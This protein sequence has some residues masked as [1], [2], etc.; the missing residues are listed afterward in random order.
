MK[1]I[2]ILGGSFAG[3]TLAHKLLKQHAS[4]GDV[5]VIIVS[6]NTHV[7]WNLASVRAIIPGQIPDEKLFQP[8]AP[9]FKQYKAD[10]FEFV[11]GKAESI[12][13]AGKKVA[14]SS[15]TG[16]NNLSYDI[17]VLATGSHTK[18]DAPW[19]G[20]DTYEETRDVLH[21]YQAKVKKASSIVVVGSGATGVET[22][23]ELGFEYGKTKKITLIAS[24]DHV[25]EGTPASVSKTATNLLKKVNVN[26]TLSTKVV[27][28]AK[29]PDGRTELTL[30]SG[31]KI[32]TDLYLPTIGLV[33]NSSYVPA[34]LL[35]SNGFVVVD[36]NLSVKGATDVWAVGDVSSIQRAQ[37]VN[38]TKQAD[39]A[40]KNIDL[41][42]KGQP[43]LPYK[44]GGDMLAVP[45]GRKAGTGHMGS[46]KLPSF[47]IVMRIIPGPNSSAFRA[48]IA[49]NLQ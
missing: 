11:L 32:T 34:D 14:V 22:S 21:D 9:G 37:I 18:A 25:L 40:A 24:G 42:I 13:V 31:Q 15:A 41:A 26:L 28:D 46:W 33:P 20:R 23:G 43:L 2:V 12:D 36:N 17:L 44:V 38:A 8:I 1:T 4:T 30:S 3:L 19:K 48:Q 47:M 27:G 10:H 29:M 39:H 5:K 45:V 49:G 6:P 7:Y 16:I 35:N